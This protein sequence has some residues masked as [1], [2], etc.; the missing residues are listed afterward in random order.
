VRYTPEG[1]VERVIEVPVSNPTC[2]CLGGPQLKTL[3]IT[4]ARK[5]L[6]RA[7]LRNQPMAGSVL[8]IDVD[9]AGMPEQ[10]FGA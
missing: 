3:Y 4:T 7:Q 1:E 5:F 8:A 6:G 10:R 2:V 9:V